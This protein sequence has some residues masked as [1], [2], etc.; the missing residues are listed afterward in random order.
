MSTPYRLHQGNSLVLPADRRSIGSVV[1]PSART[2][3]HAKYC[4][5]PISAIAIAAPAAAIF[6]I[7]A[8]A[9]FI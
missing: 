1:V 8:L 7:M 3:S 5:G 4:G 9:Y 6:W 2:R